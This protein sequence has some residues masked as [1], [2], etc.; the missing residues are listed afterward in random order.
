MVPKTEEEM[1]SMI[2]RFKKYIDKKILILNVKKSKM[3]IFKKCG[4]SRRY[5]WKWGGEETERSKN[6]NI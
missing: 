6:G 3:V 4:K 5:T 1:L 2:D